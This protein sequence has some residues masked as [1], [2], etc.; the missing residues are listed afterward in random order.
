M[1]SSNKIA[2]YMELFSNKLK[3]N[4][5]RINN[6]YIKGQS[7]IFCSNLG[8]G[9]GYSSKIKIDIDEA[10]KISAKRHTKSD[11]KYVAENLGVLNKIVE[12]AKNKGIKVLLFTPP[13]YKSY[14]DNLDSTQL[15]T[16]INAIISID[17]EFDNV[18]YY[19]FIWDT[20][21][22]ESDFYDADHLNEIGASKLTKKINSLIN[23]MD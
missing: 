3:I 18:T 9:T 2:D 10:G 15:N 8:W 21:F 5:K 16:T 14:V 19:N 7:N 20:T 17:K 13:A 11:N 12:F 23:C 1:F 6:Y 4:L 22:V